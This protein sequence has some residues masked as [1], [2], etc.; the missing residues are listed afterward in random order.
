M[1]LRLENPAALV[2]WVL[3]DMSAAGVDMVDE[4]AG[5]A[6]VARVA[7]DMLFQLN[8]E[9]IEGFSDCSNFLLPCG[10]HNYPVSS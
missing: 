7:A 5:L 3:E 6:V 1:W 8:D 2:S 10:N 4:G 9:N